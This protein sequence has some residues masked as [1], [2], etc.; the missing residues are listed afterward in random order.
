MSACDECGASPATV[1]VCMTINDARF[2]VNLCDACARRRAEEGAITLGFVLDEAATSPADAPRE[3]L[4]DAAAF[5][6]VCPVCGLT[7]EGFAQSELLGCDTCYTAH[8]DILRAVLRTVQGVDVPLAGA[9][10]ASRGRSTRAAKVRELTAEL[11]RA[12]ELEEYLKAAQLRDE[13][14]ALREPA[15]RGRTRRTRSAAEE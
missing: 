5:S 13:I 15:A 4:V 6:S 14:R 2:E 8:A 11:D 10:R 3:P 7:A 12:I 1:S 9:G